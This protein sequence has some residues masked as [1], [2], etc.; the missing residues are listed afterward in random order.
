MQALKV[1]EKDEWLV[2]QKARN[3]YGTY[4]CMT[5]T[6]RNTRKRKWQSLKYSYLYLR[7]RWNEVMTII[8]AT[9]HATVP[10]IRV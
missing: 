9:P 2:S 10:V 1:W 4:S 8:T 6:M 7:M 5:A 3:S